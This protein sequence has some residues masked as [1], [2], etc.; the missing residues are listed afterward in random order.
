MIKYKYSM[1]QRAINNDKNK[2]IKIFFEN[3]RFRKL[4]LKKNVKYD[5]FKNEQMMSN[6][7]SLIF[8]VLRPYFL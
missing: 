2:D 8:N 1:D 7:E 3:T 4:R 5:C 6:H